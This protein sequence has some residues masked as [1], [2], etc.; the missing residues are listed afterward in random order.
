HR[1]L[2]STRPETGLM[3]P[4]GYVFPDLHPALP[5]SASSFPPLLRAPFARHPV[6]VTR[7]RPGQLYSAGDYP[8]QG[9][10]GSGLSRYAGP[11]ASVHGRDLVLWVTAGFTHIPQP[12]QYPVMTSEAVGFSIPPAGIFSR[13]PARDVPASRT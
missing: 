12:E 5:L 10:P 6:W 1:S 9:R 2:E 3:R 4:P 13:T 8:N 7:Y 11:K